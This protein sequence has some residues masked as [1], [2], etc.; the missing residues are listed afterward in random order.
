MVFLVLFSLWL[1]RWVVA[2]IFLTVT[3]LGMIEFYSLL[4]TGQVKPQKITGVISGALWFCISTWIAFSGRHTALLVILPLP[5]LFL[6][7]I[8]EIFSRRPNPLQ[9]VAYTILGLIY[10]ALPLSSLMFLNTPKA[11]LLYGMPVLLLGYF[12]ITWV[13]DTGAYLFGVRF[14]RTKFFERI[15]PKKTWEGTIA[16]ALTAL[17]LTAG[18]CWVSG[19]IPWYDWFAVLMI[20]L[21]FGT[22]GDLAE[23]LFKRSLSIK[24]SGSILPGHGGILDRFD[25]IF[26]SAPF[27]I[28]YLFI[29][30]II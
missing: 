5:F 11:S 28:L 7:F 15:S 8:T 9:N 17:L 10:I 27:I 21:V 19:T 4:T 16:G 22:L 24:D 18:L 25:T 26:I 13:Y 1:S 20:V 12:L 14:G 30:N 6:P 2:A 29:R 3:V 23:S